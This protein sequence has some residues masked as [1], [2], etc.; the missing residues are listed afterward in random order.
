MQ[1]KYQQQQA[2]A[3]SSKQQHTLITFIIN[4]TPLSFIAAA[5]KA[6]PPY[7]HSHYLQ[8]TVQKPAQ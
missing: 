8:L 7:Q 6:T 1:G 2:A 3:S 5:M 4:T